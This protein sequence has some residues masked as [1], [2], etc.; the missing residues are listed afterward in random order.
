MFDKLIWEKD[1]L[2]L[3]DIVFRLQYEIADD[4]DLEDECLYFY[5]NKQIVE[6]YQHFW[7]SRQD[8]KPENIFELG[9]WDGGSL[10]FWF[11]HFQPKKHVGIDLD[12]KK[13]SAYFRKYLMDRNLGERIKTYWNTNQADAKQLTE[14]FT[15]EFSAPLDLVLDDASH[16]YEHTKASFNTLFPLLRPGGLYI[17]EDWEWAHWPD[18]FYFAKIELTKLI[19]DL[20][21][22]TG[23]SPKLIDNLTIYPGFTA[24]ERGEISISD[25]E[26][27]SLDHFIRRRPKVPEIY[28]L[29][30]KFTKQY[31]PRLI[32]C[33]QN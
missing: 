15:R 11:E 21:E 7:N 13:D 26:G 16:I 2:L 10:V 12:D 29:Y 18:H 4:W 31:L 25:L 20:V 23:S 19:F 1:R 33:N 14:I 17:I 3:D 5:K 6:N 28:R 9:I 32:K 22:A 27:F 30:K 24:V 8:F